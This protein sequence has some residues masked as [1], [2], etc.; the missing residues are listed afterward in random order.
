[1]KN[2]FWS[3]TIFCLLVACNGNGSGNAD[4]G[5]FGD[6]GAEIQSFYQE[7]QN[8]ENDR[9]EDKRRQDWGASDKKF[10]KM[11]EMNEE[12]NTRV[13][14]LSQQLE[15]IEVPTELTPS[16]PAKIVKP[17]TVTGAK[18][19]G[20]NNENMHI[21]LECVI[22]LADDVKDMP[23][24]SGCDDTDRIVYEQEANMSTEPD[25]RTGRT[26][27]AGTKVTIRISM[28]LTSQKYENVFATKK[29]LIDWGS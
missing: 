4:G 8:L 11:R 18:K 21:R 14:E 16:T 26:I 15:G 28:F 23:I 10:M 29:L 5:M 1:M 9:N 19:M 27:E 22:K 2:I 24:I 12:W 25:A 17:F 20:A 7:L 6:A 3:A 13:P